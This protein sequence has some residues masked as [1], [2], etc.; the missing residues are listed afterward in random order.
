MMKESWMIVFYAFIMIK[1]Y[2]CVDDHIENYL[3]IKNTYP[4][5]VTLSFDKSYYA[6]NDIVTITLA[7]V[8]NT[9][10]IG[11]LFYQIDTNK[12]IESLSVENNKTS[13]VAKAG[14]YEF[15]YSQYCD[16]TPTT[17]IDELMIS[18][19]K[20]VNV[21]T[22]DSL[23][24]TI[25]ENN[26]IIQLDNDIII[27][28]NEEN[29]QYEK[30][31]NITG[32][33]VLDLN[34]HSL[35]FEN[36]MTKN[37]MLL[38]VYGNVTIVDDSKDKKGLLD[39]SKGDG[40]AITVYD[41]G[42]L[43]IEGGSF[44][45]DTTAIQVKEGNAYLKGGYYSA[46]PYEGDYI[47]TI[48]C[49][50]GYYANKTAN[51][52]ISGGTYMNYDPSN[53][54]S[55]NPKTSFVV[56]GFF[57]FGQID[58]K[59]NTNYVVSPIYS[60]H[61]TSQTYFQNQETINL[62]FTRN[63][64]ANK[65]DTSQIFY[66]ISKENQFN[67]KI[68]LDEYY[69]AQFYP[70]KPGKY[71]IYNKNND[72]IIDSILVRDKI[73]EVRDECSLHEAIINNQN[74]QIINL[75]DNILITKDT[76]GDFNY[77][78]KEITIDLNGKKISV[79]PNLTLTNNYYALFIL[80]GKLTITGNGIIDYR[81]AGL[82]S[83]PV[84]IDKGGICTIENGKFIGNTTSIYSKEGYGFIKGGYFEANPDYDTSDPYR[85][86]IN[87]YDKSYKN[88]ICMFTISGGTFFK[89]DPSKAKPELFRD[90]ETFLSE[91]SFVFGSDNNMNETE[92]KIGLTYE[93]YTVLPKI[94]IIHLSSQLF[95]RKNNSTKQFK[96][97]FDQFLLTKPSTIRLQKQ[98]KTITIEEID[99]NT[100]VRDQISFTLNNDNIKY[101]GKYQITY[102]FKNN[103]PFYSSDK[104][105]FIYGDNIELF[106]QNNN[107]YYPT[108]NL[109]SIQKMNDFEYNDF[110]LIVVEKT[111]ATSLRKNYIN[112]Y[113][114][115]NDFV[116][117]ANILSMNIFF[118]YEEKIR[119][120]HLC[121][122]DLSTYTI[123][124]QEDLTRS[125]R[126]AKKGDIIQL[127]NNIDI[128]ID[129]IESINQITTSITL[130][131]NGKTVSMP[132]EM[133]FNSY[134]FLIGEGGF[135]T[136]IGNGIIDCT[137]GG[138]Y[139]Y[140][141]RVNN[142]GQLVIESGKFKGDTTSVYVT[143]GKAII[144]GGYYEAKPWYDNKGGDP[145]R[146][147]INCQDNNECSFK[148]QSKSSIEIFFSLTSF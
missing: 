75:T 144:K 136:V 130:D 148:L 81:N 102:Q 34:S 112:Y 111:N 30:R 14:K 92:T 36:N 63:T 137:K 96:L 134:A 44:H 128:T 147:T 90:N 142:G 69:Q 42:N 43:T 74:N 87:C 35:Q 40:Y 121:Y 10:L 5:S 33:I 67:A 84:R 22:F 12:Q 89:F 127:I 39:A 86:T 139:G 135:L 132:N 16:D 31:L 118:N 124:S 114:E 59:N 143:N 140:P 117:K 13:F 58:H 85:Y 62:P 110:N 94:E 68:V 78:T 15:F 71:Y 109:V 6:V 52:Y 104:F 119:I 80:G 122:K 48:N 57:S 9:L 26:T 37:Y 70:K 27:T 19:E 107:I 20:R 97:T 82:Y 60:L 1:Q 101:E 123:T 76:S 25:K 18:F 77:I 95:N 146:Y 11:K 91:K 23:F 79:D 83:Y 41:G 113:K 53:S 125:I 49:I 65:N 115:T 47:F 138:E 129:S 29:D 46:E 106:K 21:T 141:F 4:T 51:F 131:L 145:Y 61:R 103:E 2:L 99:F 8:P 55:E 32:Q 66:I 105:I 98:D 38:Y 108:N 7:I 73:I 28:K 64:N 54:Y 93:L 56:D 116:V 133:K 24:G 72:T 120:S 17:K 100:D 88:G 126:N 3:S 45:G 50:D